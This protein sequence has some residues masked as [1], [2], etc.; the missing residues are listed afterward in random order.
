MEVGDLSWKAAVGGLALAL[1]L[2]SC[3]SSALAAQPGTGT[4]APSASST[5]STTSSPSGPHD[6]TTGTRPASKSAPT[7]TSRPTT[8]VAAG[9]RAVLAS[10]P[11]AAVVYLL[12]AST[13]AAGSRLE[14]LR[15]GDG[16]GSY[17]P[18]A[19]P[20]GAGNATG[21][22]PGGR[23][24]QLEF[25]TA[26]HGYAVIQAPGEPPR[27]VDATDNGGRSWRT[28]ALPVQPH[29]EPWK[30]GVTVEPPVQSAN[31]HV[32]EVAVRCIT[33][34]DCPTYRLWSADGWLARWS[35][36]PGPQSGTF[37]AA[38]GIG[39]AV[40]GP[41]VWLVLGNGTSPIRILRSTDNA[42]SFVRSDSNVPGVSCSLTATAPRVVWR[43]CSGGMVLTYARSSDGGLHY[44]PLP[45]T[46]AGTGGT[47]LW[48]VTADTAFFRTEV[49]ADAGLF[50]STNAGRSFTRLHDY[51]AAF[52]NL[53]ADLTQICFGATNDGVAVTSNGRLY[54]TTNAGRTWQRLSAP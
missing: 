11:T 2:C 27:Q 54:R 9:A 44:S 35:S 36:R 37:N 14:L 39:L 10:E 49:G 31:G 30:A 21:A 24:T 20:P 8:G 1:A 22:R 47:A 53:G 50:R 43:S 6:A 33:P 46:G 15:S 7:S 17:Q 45:V 13:T 3:G 52:G 38:G 40:S 28:A 26:N 25:T 18:R 12:A 4:S 5:S 42:D 41:S 23:I 32:Y 16:G 51:P 19:I 29:N 34:D 48:P